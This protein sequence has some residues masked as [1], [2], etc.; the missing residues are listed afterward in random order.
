MANRESV[1]CREIRYVLLFL[2]VVLLSC[3]LKNY[4][5][6]FLSGTSFYQYVSPST[7]GRDVFSQPELVNQFY[8]IQSAIIDYSEHFLNSLPFNDKHQLMSAVVVIPLIEEVI[9]RGP[10]YLSRKHAD[11]P[12]WWLAGVLLVILFTLS[13]NRSGIALLPIFVLGLSSSW[14]I[15]ITGKFWPSLSLHIL[16]NFYFLSITLYQFTLWGD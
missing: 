3:A 6:Y 9:Y 8:K 2:A 4:L 1:L 5:F 10:L 14:L 11:S 12:V 16:Y 15:M 7:F 13:H